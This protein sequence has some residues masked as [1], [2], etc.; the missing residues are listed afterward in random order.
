LPHGFAIVID[1]GKTL[2]KVSLWSRD[3]VMLDRATRPNAAAEVD[4]IAR[5]DA[6]GIA[7]FV[8]DSLARMGGTSVEYIVPVAHGAGLAALDQGR[9]LTAPFDYEQALPPQLL[10]DYRKARAP[11]AQTGSPALPGG[12][13][14][15]AQAWWLDRL[16]SEHG[17]LLP[18]AQYWAWFLTGE[19]RSEVT[20]LG[21]HSDLWNPADAC[22][23]ALAQQQG[24]ATRF[25]P[26]ARAADIVG[27]LKPA[28]AARTGLSPQTKVLAGLH[29]SNAALL[30]ARGFAAISDAEATVLSTGTWFINMRSPATPLDIAVLPEARDCLVNVD[31]AGQPVP[32]S[33]FMGGR[34]VE[35]LG[36]AFDWPSLDGITEVLRDGAMVMPSQ[37]AGSGPF[38]ASTGHW[39]DAPS[40]PA[41]R[42]AAVA[43]YLALMADASLDLIGASDRLLIEGRYAASA[44]FTG[45]LAALRPAT[46]VFTAA[47]QVDVS[48]GALRLVLPDLAPPMDLQPVQPLDHDLTA[49]RQTWRNRIQQQETTR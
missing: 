33:R 2:S 19:A 1:V 39:I 18:W 47:S 40:N 9:L 11:F 22:F 43:L 20:S 35:L 23:S 28:I 24:W 36:E 5:L 17:T 25:A 48:F 37:V 14:L 30:A 4:G 29:D 41:A 38:S 26:L 42:R 3:G 49:Y 27:T 45:A 34:E 15:G 8:L 21:C 12:L 31:V 16:H 10:A 6:D 7:G 44:I 32:S 46:Q 13:N